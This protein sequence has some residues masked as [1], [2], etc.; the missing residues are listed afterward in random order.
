MKKYTRIMK[1]SKT[2]IDYII[3]NNEIVSARNNINNK[4]TDNECI[5]ILSRMKTIGSYRTRK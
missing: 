2:L 5:D 4:I 1:D 3:T